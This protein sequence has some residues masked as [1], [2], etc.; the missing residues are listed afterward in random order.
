MDL[1]NVTVM[2]DKG[3]VL[4][5]GAG[6]RTGDGLVEVYA[7]NPNLSA[8]QQVVITGEPGFNSPVNSYIDE[9]PSGTLNFK[10]G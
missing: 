5:S 4:I 2:T 10:I 9:E 8:G 6:G 1:R 3:D 7:D